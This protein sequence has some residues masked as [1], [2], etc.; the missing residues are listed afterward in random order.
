M[1]KNLFLICILFLKYIDS[2][3]QL[4]YAYSNAITISKEELKSEKISKFILQ[5][6]EVWKQKIPT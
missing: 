1:K 2:K 4:V 3:A 6:F 5:E